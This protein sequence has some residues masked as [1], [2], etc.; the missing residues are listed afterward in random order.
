MYPG[1]NLI[2]DVFAF[3]ERISSIVDSSTNDRDIACESQEFLNNLLATFPD[4]SHLLELKADIESLRE[5]GTPSVVRLYLMALQKDP[6]NATAYESLG[7]VADA[8]GDLEEAELWFRKAL[9]AQQRVDSYVGL[10][11][12]LLQQG[13]TSEAA[14]VLDE[15]YG[16][17]EA[18]R[19]KIDEFAD[20]LRQLRGVESEHS[21]E[22]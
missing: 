20:E 5:F 6:L 7:A 14:D 17:L 1:V 19:K 8:N 9:A 21:G 22:T 12:C 13:K 3:R 2:F 11:R 18:Q 15:A 16:F 10:C 4:S